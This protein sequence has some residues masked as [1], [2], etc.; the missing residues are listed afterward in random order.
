MPR[1]PA[2]MWWNSPVSP[3]T[4]GPKR[5][6]TSPLGHSTLTT[7]A[8]RSARIR[9]TYGPAIACDRS[10]TRRPPSGLVGSPT[11]A[12]L[13][14]D[15]RMTDRNGG[16]VAQRFEGRV[17]VVNGAASGIGRAIASRIVAE[18][19]AVVAGDI[20]VDGLASLQAELGDAVAT[21][22]GDVTVD[23]DA[24]ALVALAVDR[25]G[26]LD[27]AFHVAGA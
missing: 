16:H 8:P 25:F 14:N 15:R 18:G 24:S 22:T 13:W 26:G 12:S 7:S 19:G 23:A 5:L 1:L 2:F 27:A 20:S 4:A 21:L 6:V 3:A 17:G 11:S 10:S 9:P